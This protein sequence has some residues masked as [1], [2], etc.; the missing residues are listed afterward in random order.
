MAAAPGRNDERPVHILGRQPE[1]LCEYHGLRPAAQPLHT[2][3]YR[4]RKSDEVVQSLIIHID[5]ISLKDSGLLSAAG[6]VAILRQTA[7][8][9]SF[10]SVFVLLQGLV[11]QHHILAGPPFI[12]EQ[13]E[14]SLLILVPDFLELHTLAEEL[15]ASKRQSP[16]AQPLH[17]VH[18]DIIPGIVDIFPDRT[19]TRL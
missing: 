5:E 8:G 17:F 1:L 16:H 19:S 7:L 13:R 10:V 12:V 11:A 2:R 14:S 4:L 15:P 9:R 3:R 18:D 6:C